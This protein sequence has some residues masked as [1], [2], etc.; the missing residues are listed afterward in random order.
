MPKHLQHLRFKKFGEQSQLKVNC[1]QLWEILKLDYG[2]CVTAV[3]IYPLGGDK[4]A[5]TAPVVA[6][7]VDPGTLLN[8]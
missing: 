3:S 8:L 1:E 6:E 2:G 4:P 7:H 5:V